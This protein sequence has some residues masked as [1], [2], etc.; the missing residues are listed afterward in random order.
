MVCVSPKPFLKNCVCLLRAKTQCFCDDTSV[1]LLL[2]F[3]AFHVS[4]RHLLSDDM[5]ISTEYSSCLGSTH[6]IVFLFVIFVRHF[7]FLPWMDMQ[8]FNF[9]VLVV[10]RCPYLVLLGVFSTWRDKNKC[11][12]GLRPALDGPE[13]FALRFKPRA[14]SQ[15]K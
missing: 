14:R 8:L 9:R 2:S 1:S 3:D 15:R 11:V 10:V 6:S 7:V 5:T 4:L 12:Q 13:A